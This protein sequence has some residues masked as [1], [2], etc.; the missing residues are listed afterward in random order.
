MFFS[1]PW[2]VIETCGS[3][4]S[5]YLFIAIFCAKMSRVNKALYNN[6]DLVASA[7][8]KSSQNFL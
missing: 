6:M 7:K 3:K 4:L 5:F 8:T 1:L 2:L